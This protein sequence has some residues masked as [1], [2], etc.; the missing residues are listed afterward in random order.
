L[1]VLFLAIAVSRVIG[2]TLDAFAIICLCFFAFFAFYSLNYR[3]LIIRLTPESLKLRF[4]IFGWV[5]PL[6][7]V[8]ECRLDNLPTIMRLGGAGI[9]FMSVHNRYVHRLSGM[10][11]FVIASSRKGPTMFPRRIP[12]ELLQH[13][14]E[15]V[16]ARTG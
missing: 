15:S 1:T 4:G 13:L 5:V 8:E 14:R 11:R 12:E 7:N 3:T 6:N 16:S 10:P 2:G 9:H